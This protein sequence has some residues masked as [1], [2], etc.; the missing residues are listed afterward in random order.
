[1]PRQRRSPSRVAAAARPCSIRS[2]IRIRKCVIEV[3]GIPALS[4]SCPDALRAV[5]S[6]RPRKPAAAQASCAAEE[7][8]RL[9]GARQ[10]GDGD[11]PLSSGHERGDHLLLLIAQVVVAIEDG[12]E[13]GL[14]QPRPR[15]PSAAA[16]RSHEALLQ[17][18]K[19][20]RRVVGRV[21][22]A[23]AA[24]DL[25]QPLAGDQRARRRAPA[26]G[27]RLPR[28]A[29]SRARR[30]DRGDRSG[31]GGSPDRARA[32]S[33]SWMR[34]GWGSR[35]WARAS[36]AVD[37]LRAEV[38]L[39]CARS[40]LRP[41][42]CRGRRRS[43]CGRGSGRRRLRQPR[44]RCL[45]ARPGPRRSPRGAGRSGRSPVARSPR[46]RRSRCGAPAT[47]PRARG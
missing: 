40:P 25:D 28:G 36:I 8:R 42:A 14:R 33:K 31:S 46:G 15:P 17:L 20:R 11:D 9:A 38:E 3:A 27:R 18:P 12:G 13:G 39:R 2:S 6:P 4:P 30:E 10:S 32:R 22:R 44:P 41:A 19:A 1:M 43:P 26:P 24:V 16:G 5:A 35:L 45:R 34:I 29:G 47:P 21:E 37:D 23:G 7:R